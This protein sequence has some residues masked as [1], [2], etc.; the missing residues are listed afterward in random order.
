MRPRRVVV[1]DELPHDVLQMPA[2]EDQE[3]V[4]NLAPCCPYPPLRERVR[5]RRSVGEVD[6][7][8]AFTAEDLVEPGRELGV[9]VAEQV[10]GSDM[11]ILKEP[12]QLTGLLDY[13]G[14][15]R[16]GGAAGE[17]DA[18][19]ADLQEEQDV[20]A[21]EPDRLHR[22]EVDRQ[23]LVGVL[24]DEVAPGALAAA[25]RRLETVVAKDVAD[26]CRGSS[27]SRA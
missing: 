24:A 10:A 2:A 5:P 16:R 7:L 21:L 22:E 23:H 9:S 20:E 25:W 12:G 19:A 3:V 18:A 17:V 1:L 26:W 8:H 15:G 4:E 6:D 13:P 27:G 14:A 11:A